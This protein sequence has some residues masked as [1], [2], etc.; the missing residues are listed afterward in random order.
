MGTGL[1]GNLRPAKWQQFFKPFNRMI[2]NA[3]EH[4][5]EPAK[6][7]N[8]G[9]F[10]R[11]NEDAE[12]GRRFT[13]VIS[14]EEGPVV[15]THRKAPQRPLGSVVIDHQI[16]VGTVASQCRPVLQ[17]VGDSLSCLAFWQH[18]LPNGKQ[19]LIETFQYGAG[20]V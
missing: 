8:S 19:I 14:D 17:R 16:A 6:R 2:G 9:Q 15:T 7:I 5:A 3:A 10:T 1:P 12:N 11:S 18:L 4:I 20:V 13:A